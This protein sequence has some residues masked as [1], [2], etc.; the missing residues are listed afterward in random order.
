MFRTTGPGLSSPVFDPSAVFYAGLGTAV[1]DFSQAPGREGLARFD[2][3][4]D[5]ITASKSI[6]RM[7]L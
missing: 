6:Q 3:T 4:I 2:Y 1:F 5:G 7:P